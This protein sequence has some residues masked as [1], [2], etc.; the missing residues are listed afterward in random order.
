MQE[1]Q[2]RSLGH[3][4]SPGGGNGNPLQYS[5][6][7]NPMDRGVWWA[8]SPWSHKESDTTYWLDNN[9]NYIFAWCR[10]QCIAYNNK[11]MY[12]NVF[13]DERKKSML[14][15]MRENSNRRKLMSRI[16][17]SVCV[18]SDHAMLPYRLMEVCVLTH[19]HTHITD[20]GW[21][22]IA[23]VSASETHPESVSR[24]FFL[25]HCLRQFSHPA[26]QWHYV[27]ASH[28]L[29]MVTQSVLRHSDSSI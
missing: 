28:Y 11:R 3:K 19:I 13:T 22:H 1:M 21:V 17:L 29:R 27:W 26:C 16:K 20:T 18:G 2:V 25:Q 10:T 14:L 6:L 8:N 12:K 5:C 9:N 24:E 15:D 4:D 7:K 23:F